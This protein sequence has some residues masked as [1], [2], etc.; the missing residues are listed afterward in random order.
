MFDNSIDFL[1]FLEGRSI[2]FDLNANRLLQLSANFLTTT[3]CNCNVVLLKLGSGSEN[4]HKSHATL[5][6]NSCLDL[7][8]AE[9]AK[10]PVKVGLVSLSCVRKK[11]KERKEIH[12][13]RPSPGSG[14]D[15]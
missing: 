9:K 1:F 15:L 7:I 6:V 10:A 13:F 3:R 4:L 2:P 8:S 12:V 5:S 14:D 11:Q